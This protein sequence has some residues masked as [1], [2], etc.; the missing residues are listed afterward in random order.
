M[1]K[2]AMIIG[3]VLGFLAV[4]AGAFGA[5]LLEGRLTPRGVEVWELAARYQMVHALALLAI[6]LLHRHR[7]SRAAD[8]AAWAML[9]GVI[10][11]S[12]SLYLL[13]TTGIGLFGAITPIGGTALLIGWIGLAFAAKR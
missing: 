6:G 2:Q 3:A 11:F 9:I 4:A 1:A 5:H 8:V 12:G 13:A 7:P 10:I